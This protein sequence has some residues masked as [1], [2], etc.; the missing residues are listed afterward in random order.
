MVVQDEWY[1]SKERQRSILSNDLISDIR[2]IRIY[3]IV[4]AYGNKMTS[5]NT[6]KT[7]PTHRDNVQFSSSLPD[8]SFFETTE[9]IQA[10]IGI[11]GLAKLH[12]IVQSKRKALSDDELNELARNFL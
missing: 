8:N 10:A 7:T 5:Q 9:Q 2:Y 12:K 4:Y 3:A 6:I 11:E 1:Q